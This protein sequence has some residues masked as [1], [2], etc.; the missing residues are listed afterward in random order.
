MQYVYVCGKMAF[1]KLRKSNENERDRAHE[2]LLVFTYYVQ[3]L[4]VTY[5]HHSSRRCYRCMV[6]SLYL[7][8][9]YLIIPSENFL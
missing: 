9:T 1:E 4:C 3:C 6:C 8:F 2:N 5:I 7:S